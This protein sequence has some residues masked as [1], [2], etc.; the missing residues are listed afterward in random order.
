MNTLQKLQIIAQTLGVAGLLITLVI[1]YRQFRM[2]NEQV[3]EVRRST[4]KHLFTFA[5]GRFD[6]VERYRT[7]Y[8]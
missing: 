6:R 8:E 4:A 1:N 7:N 5:E 2:M 3:H